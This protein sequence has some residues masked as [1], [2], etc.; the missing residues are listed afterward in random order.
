MSNDPTPGFRDSGLQILDQLL[1]AS[2]T[3]TRAAVEQLLYD[4]VTRLPRLHLLLQSAHAALQDRSHVGILTLNVSP[5]VK[6]EEMFGWDTF[7]DVIRTVAQALLEIKQECLRESDFLAELSV[8]GNS[9][10]FVLSPPRHKPV[11]AY[12]DLGLLRGRISTSLQQKLREQLAP[13]VASQFGCF[14]GCAVVNRDPNVRIERLILRALDQA[15][16]DAFHE[17]EREVSARRDS[18]VDLIDQGRIHTVYQPI[19]DLRERSVLGYEAFS[20]GPAGE[21]E[22]SEYLFKMAYETQL[23]W[24]LERRCRAVALKGASVLPRDRLLFLNIEPE[25]LFDPELN[26]WK[27]SAD[28]VGRVVL[29]I[30]ER[31]AVRDFGLF[32]R[33][34]DRVRSTDFQV[35][36]DDVGKAYSWLRLIPEVQPS[37]IKLDMAI[38]ANVADDRLARELIRMIAGFAETVRI[39]LIIE[40]VETPAELARVRD[41]GIRFAQGYLFAHPAPEFLEVDFRRLAPPSA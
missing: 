9:F 19:V 20:R 29:E 10:V 21:F 13:R 7:D 5:L 32:R 6:L 8:S 36:I 14:I 2:D 24:K 22:D 18:L 37:F 25:S 27:A 23:L 39:P 38:T 12:E 16:S 15:Y 1:L 17:R 28:L 33:A 40:G 35:A 34:L 31:S 30:T 26:Q 41:L 4:P 11:T 3:A